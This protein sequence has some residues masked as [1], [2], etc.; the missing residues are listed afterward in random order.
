MALYVPFHDC[1]LGWPRF[2]RPLP[3]PSIHLHCPPW[4]LYPSDV[5]MAAMYDSPSE[6]TL[7]RE[8]QPPLRQPTGLGVM[9]I[10]AAAMFFAVAGSAFVVRARMAGH[11]CDRAHPL[12]N[13]GAA[14][15]FIEV[16]PAAPPPMETSP[17]REV[18]SGDPTFRQLVYTYDDD[19]DFVDPCDR[20]R[21]E[22][23]EID[24]AD[25]TD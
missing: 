16:R 3:V 20:E 13:D 4:P 24:L 5:M 22:I 21:V 15:T 6:P 17:C 8:V 1:R 12:P 18:P 7:R 19:A 23:I 25:T 10:A 14:E 11:C 2:L 9:L